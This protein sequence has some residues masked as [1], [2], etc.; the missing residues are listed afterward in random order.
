MVLMLHASAMAGTP[1]GSPGKTIFEKLCDV[2][3]GVFGGVVTIIVAW[4]ATYPQRKYLKDLV[5]KLGGKPGGPEGEGLVPNL[6]EKVL[7]HENKLKEVDL[8]YGR[9][10]REPLTPGRLVHRD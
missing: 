5:E 3:L 7:R 1:S 9:W 4:I 6:E 10:A 2:F 8:P